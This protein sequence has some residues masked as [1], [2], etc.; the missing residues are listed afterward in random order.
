M[1]KIKIVEPLVKDILEEDPEARKDNFRLIMQVYNRLNENI[2]G[3]PFNLVMLRHK[4][5]GLPSVEGITRARRKL[6][7]EYD[8]L[9][10]DKETE[11]LRTKEETEYRR[12]AKE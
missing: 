7:K 1:S 10:A 3:Q 9:R 11:I 4:E 2:G 6:Q 8:Y 5:L 12:Y